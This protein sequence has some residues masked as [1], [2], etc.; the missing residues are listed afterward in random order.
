[1]R[2]CRM[3]F[4]LAATK[5][6]LRTTAGMKQPLGQ[7]LTGTKKT[8][9]MYSATLKGLIKELKMVADPVKVAM[10]LEVSGVKPIL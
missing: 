9:R 5:R 2:A 1:M 10:V 8:A 7:S 4:I 6:G 3:M